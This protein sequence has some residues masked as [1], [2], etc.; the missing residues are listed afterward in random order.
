MSWEEY[1]DFSSA[2]SRAIFAKEFWLPILIVCSVFVIVVL[3]IVIL[4]SLYNMTSKR[5]YYCTRA[6][7]VEKDFETDTTTECNA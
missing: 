4:R 1:T 3:A 5:T 7:D 6:N 2:A